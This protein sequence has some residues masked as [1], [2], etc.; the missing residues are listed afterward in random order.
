MDTSYKPDRSTPTAEQH[1][2]AKEM[3]D[4]INAIVDGNSGAI[5]KEAVEAVVAMMDNMTD[6]NERF[7]HLY[8]TSNAA[9]DNQLLARFIEPQPS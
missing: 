6:P 1:S 8:K 5:I 4:L 2:D 9:M 3:N 7:V